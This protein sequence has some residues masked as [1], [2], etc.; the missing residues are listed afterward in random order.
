MTVLASPWNQPAAIA[1]SSNNHMHS[2]RKKR[3]GFRYAPATP[4]FAAGDVKRY[5]AD[6]MNNVSAKTAALHTTEL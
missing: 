3:R 2:D 1:A 6:R 4:L 5:V